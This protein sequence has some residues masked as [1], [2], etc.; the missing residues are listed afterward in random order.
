MSFHKLSPITFLLVLFAF[1]L[2]FLEVSCQGNKAMT[3]TGYE[4]AL[5][6]QVKIPSSDWFGSA[7]KYEKVSG[8]W[9]AI[10]LITC[11]VLGLGLFFLPSRLQAGVGAALAC[12]GLALIFIFTYRVN[13]EVQ[14]KGEGLFDYNYLIGFWLTLIAYA[15]AAAWHGWRLNAQP[16]TK[17]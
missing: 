8:D 6:K 10:L 13:A 11:A 1:T 3:M 2:P 7:P 4:V 17:P 15:L 9:T 16:S 14:A 12:L 5:G